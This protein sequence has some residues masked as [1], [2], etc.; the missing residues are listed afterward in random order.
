M[1]TRSR[2]LLSLLLPLLACS[3]GTPTDYGNPNPT[4]Q[5]PGQQP[6]GQQPPGGNN[7]ITVENNRF[8]PS[9]ATVARGATVTWTWDT[10]VDSDYGR[11]CV[12]H[13]VTFATGA[14]SP[15]QS[16]GSFARQFNTGGT[17]AYQCTNHAGMSGQVVVQ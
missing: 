10:C 12:E 3:G 5:P 13:N 15:N 1:P 14:S 4:G 6:P 11:T 9:T 8:D 16:T 17:F 2:T 7:A